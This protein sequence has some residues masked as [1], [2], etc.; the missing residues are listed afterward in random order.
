MRPLLSVV[1]PAYNEQEVIG[2][3]YRRLDKVCQELG[4]PYELIFVNDGSRDD[5]LKLLTGI[6][7]K[8]PRVKVVDFSRNFGHQAAVLAGLEQ[9]KGQATVIIDCDL[10]DPPELIP[11]ML[12]LWEEGYEVV[13]GQ[14]SER[15]GES[16]FKTFTAF[17][18]YRILNWMTS[19]NIPKDTGDFRLIDEKVV[20][21]MLSLKEK[22]PF[23]RG[24]VSW[25]GF[26]QTPIVFERAERFAGETKYPLKKMFKLAGDGIF[27]FSLMP[28]RI[29]YFLGG[30]SLL[31]ALVDLVVLIVRACQGLPLFSQVLYLVLFAAFGLVFLCL[32]I[33][34]QYIGRIYDEA[35]G[36][37]VYLV[38]E[39]IEYPEV[40]KEDEHEG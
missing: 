20:R 1:I 10:Q 23:L 25:L 28:L 22:N 7:R 29:A 37:P 9:A 15:K 36:R 26:R 14:R 38:R 17:A 34:G 19:V 13:Y 39:C 11:E 6:A 5:T 30:I 12:K 40:T 27:S 18:F 3:S 31:G 24:M 2:E 35:K 16:K 4:K 32:G 21:A 33:L 8:D